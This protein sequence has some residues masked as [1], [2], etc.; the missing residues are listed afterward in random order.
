[1]MLSEERVQ[2]VLSEASEG[3]NTFASTWPRL[4]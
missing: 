4:S 1:M 2:S 3:S